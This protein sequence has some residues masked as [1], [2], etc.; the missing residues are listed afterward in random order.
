MIQSICIE[1]KQIGAEFERWKLYK[2]VSIHEEESGTSEILLLRKAFG[3]FYEFRAVV[4]ITEPIAIKIYNRK[5]QDWVE[6][7]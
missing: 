3:I 6:Q 5:I 4:F 1:Y 7:K 2:Y